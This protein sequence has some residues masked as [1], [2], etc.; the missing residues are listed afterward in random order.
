MHR[1]YRQAASAEI[2]VKLRSSTTLVELRSTDSEGGCPP[3]GRGHIHT[4]L[5]RGFASTA[6]AGRSRLH[7]SMVSA[8][9]PRLNRALSLFAFIYGGYR[10]KNI[11]CRAAHLYRGKRAPLPVQS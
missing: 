5:G 3:L 2:I 9:W 1:Q 8:H 4:K 10:V 11:S 6:R 7:C